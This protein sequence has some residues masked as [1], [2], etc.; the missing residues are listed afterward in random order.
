MSEME[1]KNYRIDVTLA[2]DAGKGYTNITTTAAGSSPED[3]E[4]YIS[5]HEGKEKLRIATKNSLIIIP[6]EHARVLCIEIKPD[7]GDSPA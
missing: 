1:E 4:Q 6:R 3:I 5:Y 7:T 2:V